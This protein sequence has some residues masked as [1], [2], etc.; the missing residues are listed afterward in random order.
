M[1]KIGIDFKDERYKLYNN[2]K[3]IVKCEYDANEGGKSSKRG[4][5]RV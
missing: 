3:G 1:D 2:E 5:T 4:K